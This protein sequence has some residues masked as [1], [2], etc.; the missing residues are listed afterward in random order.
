MTTPNSI[1]P[2]EFLDFA[3]EL[4]N[5]YSSEAAYRTIVNRSYLS[6]VLEASIKLKPSHGEFPDN[7]EFYKEVEDALGHRNAEKCKDK[8]GTL[9]KWRSNSDYK[10]DKS[11]NKVKA[12]LAFI[13]A[14]K[15]FDQLEEELL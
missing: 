2:I 15:I 3:D 5:S 10:L 13:T 12:N 7:H 11:I 1:E 9:R 14:K 8:L 6:A 4:I